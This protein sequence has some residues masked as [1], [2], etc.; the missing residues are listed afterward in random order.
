MHMYIH[1]YIRTCMLMYPYIWHVQHLSLFVAL[2][3]IVLVNIVCI[4]LSPSTNKHT[5]VVSKFSSLP[6]VCDFCLPH[7]VSLY[8]PNISLSLSLS[9]SLS[10]VDGMVVHLVK[11]APPPPGVGEYVYDLMIN[12]KCM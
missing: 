12:Y 3:L 9:L 1:S 8:L 2:K 6:T 7:F 11:S 4:F 5:C 10:G